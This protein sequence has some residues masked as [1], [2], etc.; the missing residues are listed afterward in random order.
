[1]Q[2]FSLNQQLKNRNET[3]QNKKNPYYKNI[4]IE[5][6]NKK[7]KVKIEKHIVPY[8]SRFFFILYL[9]T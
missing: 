8:F 3:T 1:M 2:S 6:I 5:A 4:I 7:D 9:N